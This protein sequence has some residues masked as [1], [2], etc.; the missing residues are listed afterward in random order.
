MYDPGVLN[1]P[2]GFDSYVYF[3]CYF[4]MM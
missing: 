2:G 1:N 4:V 3:L